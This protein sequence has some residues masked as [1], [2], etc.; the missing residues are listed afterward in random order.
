MAASLGTITVPIYAKFGGKEY[1]VG[2]VTLDAKT[3]GGK[4][5]TPSVREIVAALRKIR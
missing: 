1:H 2:D 5:K 3:S 4:V